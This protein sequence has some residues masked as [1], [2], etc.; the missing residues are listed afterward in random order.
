MV[1]LTV[2]SGKIGRPRS[3]CCAVVRSAEQSKQSRS[4]QGTRGTRSTTYLR[5]SAGACLYRLTYWRCGSFS[6]RHPTYD[7]QDKRG[8]KNTVATIAAYPILKM[9]GETISKIVGDRWRQSVCVACSAVSAESVFGGERV[10]VVMTVAPN[11]VPSSPSAVIEMQLVR[12][13]V[14]RGTSPCWQPWACHEESSSSPYAL[15]GLC[16]R[17]I[18]FPHILHAEGTIVVCVDAHGRGEEAWELENG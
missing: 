1:G 2:N 11:P 15:R 4:S 9:D 14:G 7:L 10:L 13:G 8:I 3:T 6:R 17:S 5:C 12:A 16:G 18:R